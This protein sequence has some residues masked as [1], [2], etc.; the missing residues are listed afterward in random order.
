MTNIASKVNPVFWL[1]L[2]L[3]MTSLVGPFLF[4][5]YLMLIAY[6]IVLLQFFFFGRCLMNEGHNLD[7]DGDDTFYAYL[8]EKLGFNFDRKKVRGFVRSWLYA[9]LAGIC[10]LWQLVLGY[11]PL[12]FFK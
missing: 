12:L 1:H 2:I 4:S 10:I 8:L 9:V 7:D 3:T 11:P 5:W 6:S